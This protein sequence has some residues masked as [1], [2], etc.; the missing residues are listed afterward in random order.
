[1]IKTSNKDLNKILIEE[2]ERRE[3]IRRN[4]RRRERAETIEERR[5]A[6]REKREQKI[7]EARRKAEAEA[8]TPRQR[9]ELKINTVS[10]KAFLALYY[11]KRLFIG[12]K[13]VKEASEFVKGKNIQDNEVL[14]Y[15]RHLNPLVKLNS[16]AFIRLNKIRELVIG[17]NCQ[18]SPL[19]REYI[20][21]FKGGRGELINPL[22]NEIGKE[23]AVL[24]FRNIGYDFDRVIILGYPPILEEIRREYKTVE[25]VNN[26]FYMF[27]TDK[28]PIIGLNCLRKDEKQALKSIKAEKENKET[29][30]EAK[31][32]LKASEVEENI[33]YETNYL[34]FYSS[35]ELFY[36]IK[37]V[38][39]EAEETEHHKRLLKIL[40][41]IKEK[42]EAKEERER[43]IKESLTDLMEEA[44][45]RQTLFRGNKRGKPL[46]NVKTGITRGTTQPKF[47]RREEDI[48]Q[49][50]KEV[51]REKR[52]KE[53]RKTA[54]PFKDFLMVLNAM[55]KE[56]QNNYIIARTIRKQQKKRQQI[57]EE[58]TTFINSLY[59]DLNP[60]DLKLMKAD[61]KTETTFIT[62]FELV[63]EESKRNIER[64]FKTY[65]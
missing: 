26:G 15:L 62:G 28:T 59:G 43:G 50:R 41:A 47:Q 55:K 44:E 65:E 10:N 40:N 7:K 36:L 33:E 46:Y 63:I 22:T 3:Q 35:K 19:A 27:E 11:D 57:K 8:E 24:S 42:R 60:Y 6:R 20:R 16:T 56:R 64:K 61:H 21:K 2:A 12:T 45:N 54:N 39:K 23:K 51:R 32:L 18:N 25:T 9:K 29:K 38:E 13:E 48:K 34:R 30:E 5:K 58:E 1:M 37:E 31:E 4:R 17:S 14:T 49:I 53:A 52:E